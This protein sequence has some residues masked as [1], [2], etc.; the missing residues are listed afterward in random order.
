M[1][2]SSTLFC[3]GFGY[4][5]QHFAQQMMPKG[6]EFVGTTRSEAKIHQWAEQGVT[7]LPFP[8]S[9]P[10]A[11]ED[12]L[13]KADAVLVCVPPDAEGDPVFRVFKG[14]LAQSNIKWLGY[15]STTGVYGDAG[16][17]WIDE[18]SELKPFDARTHQRCLAE[19]Q[20]LSLSADIP[21][22]IFRLAGIYGPGR[23]V[24]ERVRA[25]KARRIIKE[26][27]MF[28]RIHVYDIARILA[29]SLS[30]PEAGAIYNCCDDVPCESSKVTEF[31]CD[32]L[33]VPY[34]EA[35]PFEQADISEMMRSF[36]SANRCVSNQLIKDKLGLELA[37]ASF[38]EGLRALHNELSD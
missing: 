26:G 31:A 4:T 18:S 22:H 2:Q 14:V 5:A 10:D 34:P 32:L 15:L 29:A 20:W 6:Y 24:L 30:R 1:N 38:D 28:S 8:D 25:G 27:H 19:E 11:I 37:Y 9:T 23:N 7:L 12:H 3:F 13:A 36:Y 21:V 16:G 35:E 33:G 17:E